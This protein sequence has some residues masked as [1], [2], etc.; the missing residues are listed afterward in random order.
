[1][2]RN[3]TLL[4]RHLDAP[5]GVEADG[6]FGA[7]RRGE[8]G[9][10]REQGRK[11]AHVGFLLVRVG[12]ALFPVR[13]GRMIGYGRYLERRLTVTWG[14][15]RRE[16]GSIPSLWTLGETRIALPAGGGDASQAVTSQRKRLALLAY[17][18]IKRE[19]VPR[20]TLLALLWPELAERAS[21]RALR[22]ALHFLRDALETDVFV[23]NGPHDLAVD[24]KRLWCDAA[25]LDRAFERGD[26]EGVVDLYGGEL[27]E[28]FH[29]DGVGSDFEFWLEDERRSVRYRAR[30]AY[31]ALIR[32]R[33]DEGRVEEAIA[34]ARRALQLDPTDEISLR[35]L[36]RLLDD[37]GDR[38]AAIEAYQVFADHLRERLGVEPS[39]ETETLIE[40]VRSRR[41]IRASGGASADLPE[42]KTRLIGRRR[43]IERC[44]AILRD[45]GRLVTLTGSGGVGKSRLAIA[46]ARTWSEETGERVVH[47]PLPRH[48]LRLET[49]IA[50]AARIEL[51]GRHPWKAIASRLSEEPTLLVLDGV[52]PGGMESSELDGL[53]E[54]A[55]RARLLVTSLAPLRLSIERELPVPPLGLPPEDRPLGRELPLDSE[56]VALFVERA[57]AVEP[58]F[59]LTPDNVGA[60]VETCRRLDGVPLAIELAAAR[61]RSL[62]VEDLPR[63]LE[64]GLG[65]LSHDVVDR[66]DRQQTVDAAVWWSLEGLD[67]GARSLLVGLGVFGGEFGLETAEHVA[68]KVLGERF[69]ILP[70]LATLVER[71]LLHRPRWVDGEPRYA[72]LSTVRAFAAAELERAGGRDRWMG[73]LAEYYA[74]WATEGRRHFCRPSEGTWMDR[75]R[76]E[77]DN[78]GA[79]LAWATVHRPELAARLASA[80]WYPWVASGAIVEA[81]ARIER[82]LNAGTTLSPCLEAELRGAHGVVLDMIG[83]PQ[84]AAEAFGRALELYRGVGNRDRVG[85]CL[86]SLG[87]ALYQGGDTVGSRR[88][89]E[90]A[91]EIGRSSNDPDREAG[92]FEE[93]GK[94]ALLGD[95]VAEADRWFRDAL[96]HARRLGDRVSVGTCLVGIGSVAMRR[97]A[98]DEA[99]E[100][101]GRA[102]ST[103]EEL[104]RRVN[105][106]DALIRQ[107]DAFLRGGEAGQAGAALSR[108]LA[109]V[110]DAGYRV[111]VYDA[112]LGIA[113]LV[114]AEDPSRAARLAGGIAAWMEVEEIVEPQVNRRLEEIRSKLTGDL[115]DASLGEAWRLGRTL[116]LDDLFAIA[117]GV[118]P[119]LELQRRRA[120]VR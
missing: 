7:A 15:M 43:E 97:G 14:P 61:I 93:L 83:M 2:V 73:P 8:Q 33:R 109:I 70:A 76:L 59:R 106:A 38:V 34:L 66:P 29:V 25:E 86:Q 17:V 10:E 47:V 115:E 82:I 67:D 4:L 6:R 39:T 26:V 79:A 28:G 51:R 74:A 3:A 90:E 16:P 111:G 52:E 19:R 64:Q 88:A 118:S 41:R 75:V 117:D 96:L 85:W 91:L 100:V 35:E 57:R 69:E 62:P 45:G 13:H 102:L 49:E 99:V 11:R 46:V 30:E 77:R 98:W 72:L 116:S 112:L 21:R 94:V 37:R 87:I 54:A 78:L 50:N 95:D 48:A 55:R 22:Q 119:P 103:F 58:G 20:D 84:P 107:A 104:G 60:V 23:S 32:E 27:L 63:R 1:V 9:E 92:C 80:L 42:P 101:Y 5:L 114:R 12:P 18:A 108:A 44:L 65:V 68:G 71:G 105:V 56:A 81:R 110:R 89:L 40:A 53:G 31:R 120:E 113:E 24:P 36:V